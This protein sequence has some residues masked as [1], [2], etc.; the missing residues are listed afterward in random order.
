MKKYVYLDLK[1]HMNH[2]MIFNE[3]VDVALA[4]ESEGVMGIYVLSPKFDFNSKKKYLS[5]GGVWILGALESKD[6]IRC[7]GQVIQLPD[8]DFKQI[9]LVGFHE[10]G[11]YPDIIKLVDEN[12][13]ETEVKVMM[14]QMLENL[15]MLYECDLDSSSRIAYSA[16]TN[17]MLKIHY[18]VTVIDIT[19]KYRQLIL[20]ENEEAHIAAISLVKA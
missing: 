5:E 10:T 12:S 15:D 14:Y 9:I 11:S 8:V 16:D 13:C 2:K 18:F 20:Q 3:Y 19:H 1:Q 7:E 6:N 17:A 4:S